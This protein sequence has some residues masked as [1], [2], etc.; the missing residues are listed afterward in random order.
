MN[1]PPT[2]PILQGQK[3]TLR[4]LTAA[5]VPLLARWLFEPDVLH[6]LHISEDPPQLRTLDAVQERFERMH[7]DPWTLVWRIDTRAGRP[8]GQIE[9]VDIRPLQRRAEMHMAIGEKDAWNG[10]YGSDALRTMLTFAF[11]ELGLRRVYATPDEDNRRAIRAFEK[12]GFRQEGVLREH[13][14]RYGKPVNM[15][16]LAVLS[17]EIAVSE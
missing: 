14:L 4:P 6:F 12:C 7:A 16:M 2:A 8:I 11:Q 13:R 15:V 5:D 17:H 9:L 1:L 3:V 10:G